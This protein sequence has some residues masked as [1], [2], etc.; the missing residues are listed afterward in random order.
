M[1]LEQLRHLLGIAEAGSLRKAARG[2]E[3]SQPALTK[4]IRQLEE[5]LCAPILQRTPRGVV[6]TEYGRVVVA[7]ARTAFTELDRIAEEIEAIR[8]ASGGQVR[9]AVSPVAGVTLVPAALRR[10]R[11]AYPNVTVTVM[12]GLYP[13]ILP[14]IREREIDFAIGPLPQ[15]LLGPEFL[16]EQLFF[17]EARIGCRKSHPLANATSLV[18]LQ[19]AQWAI[20]G[21][22]RGPGSLFESVFRQMGASPPPA[23]LRFESVTSLLATALAEDLLFV[24]PIKIIEHPFYASSMCAIPVRER[25]APVPIH[26][27]RSSQ[28][29]L[30]PSAEALATA[31]RRTLPS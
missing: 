7:R 4:S 22:E 6:L 24:M 27:L 15:Q 17:S 21:P 11:Q 26:L 9:I 28:S 19:D 31:I 13:K 12:D 1:R 16:A 3:I 2:L 30:P 18:E 29:P 23:I 5:E 10:F 14:L 8:G 20:T 25:I